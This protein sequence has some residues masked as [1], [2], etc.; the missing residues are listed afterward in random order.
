MPRK[1]YR[2][3]VWA[4]PG[5]EPGT[6]V[7]FERRLSLVQG[8]GM[9]LFTTKKLNC[10]MY[11]I[12]IPYGGVPI[13]KQK[14]ENLCKTTKHIDEGHTRYLIQ[15]D[16][17]LYVGEEL[18]EQLFWDG[19]P[20]NNMATD[21]MVRTTWPGTFVNEPSG[22]EIANCELVD[23]SCT[24]EPPDY[25]G[26]DRRCIMGWALQDDYEQGV[27]ILGYYNWN[28]NICTDFK[29]GYKSNQYD[30]VTR[31]RLSKGREASR[32]ETEKEAQERADER[33]A[34]RV[35]QMR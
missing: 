19:H 30:I 5:R 6:W 10:L 20:R 31:G 11:P 21:Y 12:I 25:E 28:T 27:E 7:G 23:V 14:V 3:M 32:A 29:V 2:E 34:L 24:H 1:E 8:R 13:T 16:D 26:I 9:G 15:G 18:Q 17:D 33:T 35:L 4:R 22:M